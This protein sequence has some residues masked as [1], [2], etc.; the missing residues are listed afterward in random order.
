MHICGMRVGAG[1]ELFEFDCACILVV[2]SINKQIQKTKTKKE[3][4]EFP[5]CAMN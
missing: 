2:R 4:F 1:P 5:C 3:L